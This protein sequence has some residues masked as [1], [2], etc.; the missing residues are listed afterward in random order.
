MRLKRAS[1]HHRQ[2]KLDVAEENAR[3]V[4]GGR[5]GAQEPRE[6]K[7]VLRNKRSCGGL[8]KSRTGTS[9]W[10]PRVMLQTRDT[11]KA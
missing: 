3:A 8:S 4:I 5:T 6:W 11:E 7:K 1:F 9:P 10:C 2:E